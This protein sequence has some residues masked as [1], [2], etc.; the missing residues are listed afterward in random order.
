MKI[1]FVL[2][3]FPRRI[4]GGYKIVFEYA[5][6]LC[7]KGHQICI[8]FINDCSFKN[9][10][11][12]YIAKIVGSDYLTWK[13]PTWF[14]LD[15]RIKKISGYGHKVGKKVENQDI[16]IATAITTVDYVTRLNTKAQK[17][18][19]I[20][21]YEIWEKSEEYVHGSYSLGLKNIVISD[22]LKEIVDRYADV[23][24]TVIKNPID[25]TLYKPV[26][27]IKNR[28]NHSVSFLYHHGKH[29]GVKYVIE[30]IEILKKKYPDLK[31]HAFGTVRKGN[32]LPDYVDYV[33]CATQEQTIEIYNSSA[34]FMCATINEGYGLTG[35]EAMACGTVLVSTAYQ[36]V[37]EY[38]ENEKNALLSPVKDVGSLVE[39]VCRLFEDD[40]LR[41]S[42][43]YA[44]IENVAEGFT[45]EKA[46]D[47]F[48]R[49][50]WLTK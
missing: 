47:K 48:E 41:F 45:W 37:F 43:A 11:I 30:A 19:F 7:R 38:A 34:I 15:V 26:I 5:N 32:D 35:L 29:K 9:Y 27:D 39:N 8:L 13:H 49:V 22:W 21:D 50:L 2:P 1:C 40:K 44:G 25:T 23:P 3:K 4:I 20:Q 12:P 6:R 42:L 18:Y 16:V 10:R 36:G 28:S 33:Y 31:V 17:C 46:V 14:D 24:C